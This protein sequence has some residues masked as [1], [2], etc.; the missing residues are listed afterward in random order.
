MAKDTGNRKGPPAGSNNIVMLAPTGRKNKVVG[1][2]KIIISLTD[3]DV[4]DM[5]RQIEEAIMNRKAPMFIHGGVLV[6]PVTDEHKVTGSDLMV[7]STRLC[8]ITPPCLAALLNENGIYFDRYDGRIKNMRMVDPP[9]ALMNTVLSRNEWDLPIV[10][11]AINVPSMR[12]DGSLITAPGYD[13]ATQLWLQP[14]ENVALPM[15]KD[16]P[17]MDDA[18][19]ALSLFEELIE[20]FP[21]NEKVDKAVA[22]AG[23]LTVILRAA[24]DV[25]PL[26]LVQAHAAGS[27]KSYLVNLMVSVVRGRG[28]P[29]MTFT[30]NQE[31]MDKRLSGVVLDG[32]PFMS[33]D[34][35]SSDIGGDMLCQMTEQM[36]VTVRR[37][38]NSSPTE[39][40]WRGTLFATGNNVTLHGDMSRRGTRCH[41]DPSVERPEFR[42]FI[43]EPM[44]QVRKNRGKY[45]AAAFTIYRAYMAA[46]KPL[47]GQCTSL[48][49]YEGWSQFVCEPLVW[50][51]YPNP[52]ASV[53]Q[54]RTDD[55]ERVTRLQLLS[56]WL[57][58]MPHPLHQ[59]YTT[60][61]I[62]DIASKC[63][64]SHGETFAREDY[65]HRDFYT[66]LVQLTARGGKDTIDILRLGKMLSKMQGLVMTVDGGKYSIRKSKEATGKRGVTWQLMRHDVQPVQQDLGL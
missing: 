44:H 9:L 60:K 29:V 43:N 2:D 18:V 8:Q 17:S 55:P 37:L 47:A 10:T 59:D 56:L 1:D 19:A 11:N 32:L 57:E 36:N 34:N 14:D 38:G 27:G 48:A 63:E 26:L 52:V 65:V 7:Y 66:V 50:L 40:K 24:F 15:V 62:I 39:C 13:A 23:F 51:G 22:L 31:E 33:L 28:C 20:E 6:H 58:Y 49:S 16:K 25:A 41:L 30:G 12:S 64:V 45:L 46:G 5:V 53:E 42:K 61:D 3:G 4:S 54:A 21:F 35:L